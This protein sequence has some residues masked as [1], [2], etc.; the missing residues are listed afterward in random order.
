MRTVALD[1]GVRKICYC[2]VHDGV[3]VARATARSLHDL[4]PYLGD[5][6]TPARVAF[7]ACR[8]AW[9][10][11]DVLAA[12]GHEPIMIDTTRVARIG[13]GQH[14]AKTDRRDALALAL[15]LELNNIPVAH[16]LTP[17]R[18]RL[19]EELCTRGALVQT[20]AQYIT[21][22]RGVVR[23]HGHMLPTG[24][25][26]AFARR[27]RGAELSPEILTIIE[28]L[29]DILDALALRLVAV[30]TRLETLARAAP[31]IA[32][33]AT[34][35][36]VGLIVAA[37]FVASLDEAGRFRDAHAV[38]AYLGLVPCEDSSGGRRRLGA[39]TKQGNPWARAALVQ[40]AH[41]ILRSAPDD[42]PLKVWALDVAERRGKLIAVVALARRLTG[43]LWAMWHRGRPYDP[44]R[45]AARSARGL[46]A[47]SEQTAQRAE[48]QAA[49]A[50]AEHK[51]FPK[52]RPSRVRRTPRTA[53]VAPSKG[54]PR[55]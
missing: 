12:R 11:Y 45:L 27:V 53:R 7:E 17:E 44:R 24:G 18:R 40:A 41:G 52:T 9:H 26:E 29:L 30:E 39:I 54:V 33:L 43:V 49:I 20:R 5:K 6:T 16:V 13:V 28:P 32:L 35:P 34:V 2:E 38:E 23:A 42:D 51:I 48:Q 8:E 21:T 25:P 46:E 36:G 14:G 15:A 3:V 47:A 37:T 19:R 22:I 50:A 4:D 31:E 55:R 1:L 10:V